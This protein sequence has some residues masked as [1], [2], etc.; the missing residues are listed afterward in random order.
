MAEIE[1]L[2]ACNLEDVSAIMI[3]QLNGVVAGM[4][5]IK[6]FCEEKILLL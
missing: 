5:E 6:E 2:K 4:D 1:Q 3:T